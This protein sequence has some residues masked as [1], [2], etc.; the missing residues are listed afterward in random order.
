MD[1]S[2]LN[3]DSNGY[4]TTRFVYNNGTTV[5]REWKIQ[6]DIPSGSIIKAEGDRMQSI[7]DRYFS[8]SGSLSSSL[9]LATD[10]GNVTFT[11]ISSSFNYVKG[12]A[13]TFITASQNDESGRSGITYPFLALTAEEYTQDELNEECID[14]FITSSQ[15]ELIIPTPE[16]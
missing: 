2:V 11:I 8:Y 9:S 1:T 4:I 16:F 5:D 7:C 14:F 3:M 10:S 12:Q 15:N 13:E 6:T